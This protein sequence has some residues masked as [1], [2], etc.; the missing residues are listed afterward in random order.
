VPLVFEQNVGQ[1][2]ERPVRRVDLQITGD[3]DPLPDAS[4]AA[5]EDVSNVQRRTIWWAAGYASLATPLP[6]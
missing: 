4:R 5:P 3:T 2:Q 1:L 6:D